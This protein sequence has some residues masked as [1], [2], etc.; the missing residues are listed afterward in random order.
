MALYLM[1]RYVLQ[2]E[3]PSYYA[4][5]GPFEDY[6]LACRLLEMAIIGRLLGIECISDAFKPS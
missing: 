4:W 6:L 5:H 3:Q 1:S 2:P